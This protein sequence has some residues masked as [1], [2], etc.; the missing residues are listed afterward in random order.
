MPPGGGALEW[1]TRLV[2]RSRAAL[3]IVLGGD[4][5]DAD[6][7]ERYGWVYRSLEDSELDGFVSKF[8]NRLASYDR[9]ATSAVKGLVNCEVRGHRFNL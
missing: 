4:D 5:F 8:A 6:T 2:G 1:L 7:A 3:E 9:Q